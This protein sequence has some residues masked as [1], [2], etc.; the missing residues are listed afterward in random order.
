MRGE[1]SFIKGERSFVKGVPAPNKGEHT[2]IK[3]EHVSNRFAPAPGPE[4]R[5]IF[6]KSEIWLI[7]L[8]GTKTKTKILLNRSEFLSY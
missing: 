7:K 1:R 2:F 8:K 6:P 4:L 3:G 5:I